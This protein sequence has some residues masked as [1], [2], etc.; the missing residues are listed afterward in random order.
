MN[1]AQKPYHEDF[2]GFTGKVLGSEI[3]KILSIADNLPRLLALEAAFKSGGGT[4]SGLSLEDIASGLPI[5]D[6]GLRKTGYSGGGDNLVE[7]ANSL[8][9]ITGLISANQS[10]G[11]SG[12]IDWESMPIDSTDFYLPVGNSGSMNDIPID[13][14][15]LMTAPNLDNIAIC[16]I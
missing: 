6:I 8:P 14:S 1:H 10:G 4:A 12:E 2:N 5:I 9:I 13:G 11:A 15:F 3:E 7:T 16:S